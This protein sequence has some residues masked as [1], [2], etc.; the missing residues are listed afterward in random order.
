ML[1]ERIRIPHT[2]VEL[3]N[4]FLLR[5]TFQILSYDLL[6]C[7]QNFQLDYVFSVKPNILHVG[8]ISFLSIQLRIS[9]RQDACLHT[10]DDTNFSI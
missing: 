6:E 2:Y 3:E 9:S 4:Q 5:S 1:I 10:T 7:M 8:S